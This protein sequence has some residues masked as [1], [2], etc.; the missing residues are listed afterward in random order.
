[1][2]LMIY[3]DVKQTLRELLMH[4]FRL[5]TDN[6]DKAS[7]EKAI[8]FNINCLGRVLRRLNEA[9]LLGLVNTKTFPKRFGA[10]AQPKKTPDEDE[11]INVYEDDGRRR[12]IRKR[13]RKEMLDSPERKTKTRR[14]LTK[15]QKTGRRSSSIMQKT[16]SSA[17]QAVTTTVK[18][19]TR[20]VD[21]NNDGLC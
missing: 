18:E 9:F 12:S 21:R 5:Y 2:Q 1:M 10:D 15:N 13:R 6:S 19:L 20:K 11:I 7:T 14:N 16:K 4:P 17:L 3:L 8:V